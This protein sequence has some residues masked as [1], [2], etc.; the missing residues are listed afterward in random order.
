MNINETRCPECGHRLKLKAHL[1]QGQRVIC[2]SC[3]TSLTITNLNPIELDLMVSEKR[4]GNKKKRAS[5]IDVPCP[6]CEA[7]LRVSPHIQQGYRVRCNN[8]HT[9]LEVTGTNPLE[10]DVAM[11][12]R[13]K[14]S[15]RDTFD[16]KLEYS[17]KKAG[18][19]RK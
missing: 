4:N 19:V 2:P 10:L 7:F 12:A 6:E 14:Y 15:P 9:M 5:I 8:C 16:E 3:G 13:L 18:R 11:T 1:H 17:T